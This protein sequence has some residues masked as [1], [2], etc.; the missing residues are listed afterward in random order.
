MSMSTGWLRT[1]VHER[2]AMEKMP[3]ILERKSN[4]KR[5]WGVGG[6]ARTQ[7]EEKKIPSASNNTHPMCHRTK[8]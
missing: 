8:T 6:R 7:S 1:N 4:G 2:R 5:G 3:D